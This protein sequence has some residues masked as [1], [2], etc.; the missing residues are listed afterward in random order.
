MT[1]QEIVKLVKKEIS[2]ATAMAG[3]KLSE[4]TDG[5]LPTA[6]KYICA[7]NEGVNEKYL[8]SNIALANSTE[9]NIVYFSTNG[10]DD[11]A[12]H[13]GTASLPFQT[14]EFA[15]Q[16]CKLRSPSTSNVFTILGDGNNY[17]VQNLTISPFINYDLNGG[18]LTI[19]TV[20]AD[21]DWAVADGSFN[22]V[23][24]QLEM[25]APGLMSSAKKV[26]PKIIDYKVL[27]ETKKSKVSEKVSIAA[28]P[29]FDLNISTNP[30][31]THSLI[32]NITIVNDF[33]FN[34]LL[35]DTTFCLFNNIYN[36][37]S[38]NVVY[39]DNGNFFYRSS[40]A[41]N[42]NYSNSSGETLTQLGI[43]N[44]VVINL[45]TGIINPSALL[46]LVTFGSFI[47]NYEH[48]NPNANIFWIYDS[49]S[50]RTP[51]D[52]D[53]LPTFIPITL[54][55]SINTTV[56]RVNYT[57][58]P[59]PVTGA[60]DLESEFEGIDTALAGGIGTGD[61]KGPASAVNDNIATYDGT[62]GKIIKEN[63]VQI[64]DE[65]ADNKLIYSNGKKLIIHGDIGAA[66]TATSGNVDIDAVD[67]INLSADLGTI[68]V[69]SSSPGVT[70]EAIA[71]SLNIHGEGG[72][73]LSNGGSTNIFIDSNNDIGLNA[74]NG[75][76]SL[77]ALTPAVKLQAASNSLSL[78]G[79]NGIT[80]DTGGNPLN[81]NGDIMNQKTSIPTAWTGIWALPVGGNINYTVIGDQV[82]LELPGGVLSTATISSFI[83]CSPFLPVNLRPT[84]PKYF[85]IVTLD[86]N[87]Q[88][89][90]CLKIDTTGQI[91]IYG[92]GNF[93]NFSG[94]SALGNS[95]FFETGVRYFL[96]A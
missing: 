22:F 66:I 68:K 48:N 81:I 87:V 73:A 82:F 15:R 92:S 79:A 52:I 5:G 61:V 95:G 47:V 25:L 94:L 10:V 75:V 16:Q 1:Q 21:P 65:P 34:F 60:I 51:S 96:G 44:S 72:L 19:E 64:I 91:S 53:G 26:K 29:V 8:L 89:I 35:T 41:L 85:S 58:V 56:P 83:Q 40:S 28:V 80:L 59:N 24:T 67:D 38:S 13:S 18:I 33:D 43:L 46:Q 17:F 45:H 76:I 57:P 37:N 93:G 55:E 70:I 11:S 86:N 39:V 2:L 71:Q 6:A 42:L 23:R 7:A 36:E 62:T 84:T 27:L 88:S 63:G 90:N 77:S 31:L 9:T 4:F 12:T 54:P 69:S 50:Y 49:I 32:F 3:K 20:I 74:D 78:I 30:T 14:L